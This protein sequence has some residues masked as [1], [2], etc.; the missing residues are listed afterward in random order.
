MCGCVCFARARPPARRRRKVIVVPGAGGLDDKTR[1]EM[2]QMAAKAFKALR[3]ADLSSLPSGAVDVVVSVN[4]L[5]GWGT[6]LPY[7]FIYFFR[8]RTLPKFGRV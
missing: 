7:P 8:I 1:R 5:G 2:D 6:L 3:V 4:K